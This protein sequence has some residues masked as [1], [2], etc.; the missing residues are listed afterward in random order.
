VENTENFRGVGGRKIKIVRKL[1]TECFLYIV[2]VSS[3][4]RD[5][6]ADAGL[7]CDKAAVFGDT[8]KETFCRLP[9]FLFAGC[10]FHSTK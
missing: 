3:L 5:V 7:L 9:M 10:F 6:P 4:S 1:Y 8:V 2:S